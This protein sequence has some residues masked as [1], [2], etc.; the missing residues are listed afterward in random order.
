MNLSRV[1]PETRNPLLLTAVV[2]FATA[3]VYI[4]LWCLW[5]VMFKSASPVVLIGAV[6]F[7][8]L[9]YG[10]W[11][12][13]AAARKVAIF[14]LVLAFF[15][16]LLGVPGVLM[17]SGTL[18]T[19]DAYICVGPIAVLEFLCFYVFYRYKTAFTGKGSS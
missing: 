13:S 3:C 4:A 19:F 5:A 1:L 8:M 9:T 7:G 14:V 2:L 11:T 17:E 16:T 18:T 12:L 6:V 15:F 10:T